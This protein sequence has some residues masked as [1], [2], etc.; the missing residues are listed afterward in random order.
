MSVKKEWWWPSDSWADMSE[1]E[2]YL[3]GILLLP[4]L[5]FGICLWVFQYWLIYQASPT[6]FWWALLFGTFGFLGR[7]LM[8]LPLQRSVGF[9]LSGFAT[10]VW[11]AFKINVY[12][13]IFDYLLRVTAVQMH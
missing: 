13:V 1:G 9:S 10:L 2:R 12:A 7:A 8:D 6:F 5:V 3:R 4:Y 11:F